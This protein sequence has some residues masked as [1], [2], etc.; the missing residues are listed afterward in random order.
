MN[1]KKHAFE[2]AVEVFVDHADVIGAV[3]KKFQ[4]I[5]LKLTIIVRR[6]QEEKLPLSSVKF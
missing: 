2:R 5:N 4:T 1:N 3:H 6:I